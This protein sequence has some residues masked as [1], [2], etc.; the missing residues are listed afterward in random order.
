MAAEP[1]RQTDP[2]FID[3]T[4]S[5]AVLPLAHGMVGDIRPVLLIL[6]G[7]VG[8]VLLIS[9]ASAASRRQLFRQLL[10]ENVLFL[11]VDYPVPAHQRSRSCH[12]VSHSARLASSAITASFMRRPM[13]GRNMR[14][15]RS[16]W[17]RLWA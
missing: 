15:W 7:A 11:T 14:V 17:R 6:L 9:C 3:M 2:R 1:F 8:F 16:A 10:T 4:E 5:V 13:T 12:L